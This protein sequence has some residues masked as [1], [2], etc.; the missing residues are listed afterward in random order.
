MDALMQ[1]RQLRLDELAPKSGPQQDAILIAPIIAA[2]DAVDG[3]SQELVDDRQLMLGDGL[4]QFC[5]KGWLACGI[6]QRVGEPAEAPGT[7]EQ[8]KRVANHP[9]A[10][11]GGLDGG[12]HLGQISVRDV[13]IDVWKDIAFER[14]LLQRRL[15]LV[16]GAPIR[17]PSGAV[18][19]SNCGRYIEIDAQRRD[20]RLDDGLIDLGAPG[21]TAIVGIQALGDIAL[22]PADL[23]VDGI[24]VDETGQPV[25]N[26]RVR[27]GAAGPRARRRRARPCASSGALGARRQDEAAERAHEHDAGDREDRVA[28]GRGLEHEGAE[29]EQHGHE[30]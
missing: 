28:R 23:I 5:V 20:G 8:P 16:K 1:A 7:F 30:A 10:L 29:G 13:R 6:G 24:V 18:R 22:E 25:T 2:H 14:W 9:E 11:R 15:E 17:L 3:Q 12:P 4:D 27:A 26:V 21:T 19:I